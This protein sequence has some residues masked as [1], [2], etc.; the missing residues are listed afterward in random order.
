MPFFGYR[1][2]YNGSAEALNTRLVGIASRE[3]VQLANVHREFRAEG[4]QNL[5][6]D[7]LHPNL[8]AT[9]ILFVSI[10][11]KINAAASGL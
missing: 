5:F 1:S 9:R 11:E 6:P 3:R 8:D 4:S 7:G 2:L 10:L